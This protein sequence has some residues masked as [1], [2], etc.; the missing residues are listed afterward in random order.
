MIV[1][2]CCISIACIVV[3]AGTVP[4]IVTNRR[5]RPR[6]IFAAFVVVAVGNVAAALANAFGGNLPLLAYHAAMAGLAAWLA[7]LTRPR[8]R[9]RVSPVASRVKDLGH[10]LTVVP[11][12]AR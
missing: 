6:L 2:L 5:L 10:R 9:R 7:W 11:V 4:V 12:G 8:G 1:A 3:A